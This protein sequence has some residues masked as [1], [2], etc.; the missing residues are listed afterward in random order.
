MKT[1]TQIIDRSEN[2]PAYINHKT[3]QLLAPFVL[4][5]AGRVTG[6]EQLTVDWH[7]HSGVATVTMPY[8]AQLKHHDSMGNQDT[9]E[10]QGLQ[11]MASGKGVWHKEEY[12]GTKAKT[13]IGIMQL[14]VLLP[15]NEEVA[16]SRYF[17]LKNK[18]I[19]QFK[20]TRILLGSYQGQRAHQQISQDVSYLD[21]HLKAGESWF[22]EHDSQTR[23]F[24][25]PR[26]GQL[27][28]GNDTLNTQSF[29]LLEESNE[30]LKVTALTDSQ[31]VLAASAPWKHK[32]V[33]QYGQMHSNLLALEIA[34]N[35]IK[36]L[37]KHNF[38]NG[39]FEQ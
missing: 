26:S 7:P 36:R 12:Q 31:F 2:N 13:D 5:D 20:N 33:H 39:F 28:V 25:Y 22:F 16:N 30:P 1:L 34:S 10:D 32:I 15:P 23:G 37:A 6:K 19:T 21:V 8:D 3:R 35:E 29:G 38:T 24:L 18:E 14:W 27:K 11:W 17:S 4:F 9:I